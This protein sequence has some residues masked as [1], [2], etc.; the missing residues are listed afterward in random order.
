MTDLSSGMRC[1]ADTATQASTADA[2]EQAITL[3]EKAVS[4]ISKL[5]QEMGKD[6]LLLRVGVKQGGCSGMSYVMDFEQEANLKGDDYVI[7]FDGFKL[8]CDPK[9]LLY[10]FGMNLDYSDALIGG[11]FNFSNPNAAGNC[12]CGKSFSV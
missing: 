2:P 5:K 3:S 12:G 8:A 11:G 7:Q 4:H 10:L 9:S 1:H 6:N